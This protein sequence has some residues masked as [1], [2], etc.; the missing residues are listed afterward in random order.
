M[1]ERPRVLI[2]RDF[3]LPGSETFIRNQAEGLKHFLAYYAGLT[4]VP[5]IE[6]PAERVLEVCTG[7]LGSLRSAA[8]TRLGLTPDFVYRVWKLGPSLIHAHFGVDGSR[9]MRLARTLRLPLLV[10]LHD[11]DITTS[12]A[13]LLA[14]APYCKRYIARRP[15]LM[16]SASAFL[17][18]SEFIKQKA[19]ERGFPAAK[20]LVHYM[21]IDTTRFEPRLDRS[22]TA[23]IVLFVGRLVEKKGC[24]Y[25]IRAMARVRE[26]HPEAELVVIGDGPLRAELEAEAS[27][28]LE[29]YRF[30]GAQSPDAVKA[31]YAKARV[32]C[33]PSVTARSGETEGLTTTV[34]EAQAA[35]LPVVA[36]FHSGVPEAVTDDQTGLLVAEHDSETLAQRLT[37]LLSQPQLA[38]RL[39]TQA[40]SS[41][42]ARFDMARQTALLETIYEQLVRDP[43]AV[44][45][46]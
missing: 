19:V 46:S 38:T 18:V 15:R 20:I 14:L 12:D 16:R 2:Y 1:I 35:G 23:P 30:L 5:G 17:A 22:D 29:R 26:Q 37:T 8:F 24:Q 27:A 28:K 10:T 39:A 43:R 42:L 32:F 40:R 34:L 45:R 11:Y 41:V 13:D 4:R 36:T 31:W 9:V 3:L 6:L 21:G 33:A 7:P 44:P 25:L